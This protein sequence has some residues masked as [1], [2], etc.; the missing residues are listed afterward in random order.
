MNWLVFAVPQN[1]ECIY[2]LEAFSWNQLH[3]KR[4]ICIRRCSRSSNETNLRAS[5]EAEMSSSNDGKEPKKLKGYNTNKDL[6][7]RTVY[8]FA[9]ERDTSNRHNNC[10]HV[11][12][13]VSWPFGCWFFSQCYY[14]FLFLFLFP[15]INGT[16]R[17]VNVLTTLYVII[18]KF[19]VTSL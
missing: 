17:A 13:G 16:S 18:V 7:I 6:H 19:E 8:T 1:E 4:S 5:Q 11:F 14:D 2:S 10:N 12:V 3:M 9:W 15:F